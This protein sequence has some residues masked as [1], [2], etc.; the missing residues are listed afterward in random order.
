MDTLKELIKMPKK[1][2]KIMVKPE[3][4]DKYV[5][6]GER[7]KT[8]EEASTFEGIEGIAGM[9]ESYKVEKIKSRKWKY[10]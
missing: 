5:D 2:Y 7:F 10:G 1:H 3:G 9:G 8:R 6:T 4:E